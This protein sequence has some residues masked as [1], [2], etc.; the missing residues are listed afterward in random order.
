MKYADFEFGKNTLKFY[1]SEKV[2][3]ESFS[4]KGQDK[5]IRFFKKKGFTQW[6][7]KAKIISRSGL[8][9]FRDPFI[10]EP[11]NVILIDEAVI[12]GALVDKN[13][14][15]ALKGNIS[16]Y[17]V[18]RETRMSVGK[19]M[20]EGLIWV[21]RG[22]MICHP[23]SLIYGEVDEIWYDKET[24]IYY[25]GDTKTSSSVDKISYWYQLS[26]YIEILRELNPEVIFSPVGIIDWTKIKKE[27]WV[28]NK[29][30]DETPWLEWKGKEIKNTDPVYRAKWNEKRQIP[31][32]ETN[33]LIKRDLAKAKVLDQAK[34]DL[35]LIEKYDI[36]S[37]SDFEYLL[38]NNANFKKENDLL[39]QKYEYIKEGIKNSLN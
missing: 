29:D 13:K 27:K 26:I 36:S 25:V 20:N 2:V 5:T 16:D 33:L 14:E 24:G 1:D 37:V 18:M 8:S 34:S 35:L 12:Y 23:N 38:G 32:E 17:Q 7:K 31:T 30:F 28:F 21:A 4:P 19:I 22:E 3:L 10:I 11:W 15:D 39:Q 6:D 9:S